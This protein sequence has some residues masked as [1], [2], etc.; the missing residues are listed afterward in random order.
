MTRSF[1]IRIP[2][3]RHHIVDAALVECLILE[4]E[5][6]L[7]RDIRKRDHFLADQFSHRIIADGGPS[8]EKYL[9][10]LGECL[11]FLS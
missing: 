3:R 6:E 10:F 5:P 1:S 7:V 11:P 9:I 2:Q 4:L 8:A